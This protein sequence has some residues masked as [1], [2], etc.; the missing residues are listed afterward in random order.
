VPVYGKH[1]LL[2][3][4]WESTKFSHRRVEKIIKF[5]FQKDHFRGRV[6]TGPEG[7]W[8]NGQDHLG[9]NLSLIRGNRN[10]ERGEV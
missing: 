3:G 10:R 5:L 7:R 1:S 8:E 2:C 6:K 9:W 4:K